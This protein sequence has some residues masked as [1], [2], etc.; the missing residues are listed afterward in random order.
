LENLRGDVTTD[1]RVLLKKQESD[2]GDLISGSGE[3]LVRQAVMKTI[4][5]H[6]Q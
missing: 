6:K 1:E 4:Y 3:G 2:N 5:F